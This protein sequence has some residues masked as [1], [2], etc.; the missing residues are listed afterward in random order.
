[1]VLLDGYEDWMTG[2]LVYDRVF[3]DLDAVGLR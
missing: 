2:T 1:M 3:W